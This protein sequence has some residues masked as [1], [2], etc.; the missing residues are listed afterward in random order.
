MT[1]KR[2][3]RTNIA[4]IVRA[5][6]GMYLHKSIKY[7]LVPYMPCGLISRSARITAI[8]I[9]D[10]VT[11]A[12]ANLKRLYSNDCLP[13]YVLSELT[14][15][16]SIKRTE[17]LIALWLHEELIR[18]HAWQRSWRLIQ[19]CPFAEKQTLN[20][21]FGTII[22]CGMADPFINEAQKE[23][24]LSNE[25]HVLAYNLRKNDDK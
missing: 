19:T 25:L 2:L 20:H 4:G 8:V 5:K 23:C 13:R 10:N 9:I 6:E 3:H 15:T 24:A 11:K 14:C 16:K 17:K 18:R 22:R 7:Q 21:P 1:V 12:V